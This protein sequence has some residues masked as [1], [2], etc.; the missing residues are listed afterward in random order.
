MF[1]GGDEAYEDVQMASEICDKELSASMA[2]EVL[3]RPLETSSAFM[4]FA[5]GRFEIGRFERSL[6]DHL[7]KA[8]T[9]EEYRFGEFNTAAKKLQVL[10]NSLIARLPAEGVP[11]KGFIPSRLASASPLCH[12]EL[13]QDSLSE[14]TVFTSWARI[15]LTMFNV[16]VSIL[17]QKVVLDRD[18]RETKRDSRNGT[19]V[20]NLLCITSRSSRLFS[21]GVIELR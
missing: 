16:E 13:Y 7:Y 17:L 8:R 1:S 5:I 18:D 2:K 19:G 4:L 11:E 20:Y 15:V 3:S 6:I 9:S 14:P 12:K 21:F 10:I